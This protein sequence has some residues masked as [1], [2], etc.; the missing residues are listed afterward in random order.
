[1]LLYVLIISATVLQDTT[2]PPVPPERYVF[3]QDSGLSVRSPRDTA[4]RYYRTI[5]GVKFADSTSGQTIRA[6]LARHGAAIVAGYRLAG[7]AYAIRI[8]DPGAASSA[9]DSVIVTLRREPGVEL[10][11]AIA[12][13][14]RGVPETTRRGVR[15]SG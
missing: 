2:R 4:V 1:M 13:M 12:L 9:L 3:P 6:V 15:H 7:L 11:W 5:V 10:A 8:P 14:N